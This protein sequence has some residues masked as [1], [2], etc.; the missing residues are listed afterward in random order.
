MFRSEI[1]VKKNIGSIQVLHCELPSIMRWE[2]VNSSKRTR[3][4]R[5]AELNGEKQE[6]KI[7]GVPEIILS[8][9]AELFPKNHKESDSY[10][11]I[12][13]IMGIVDHNKLNCII[14]IRHIRQKM[15]DSVLVRFLS[16]RQNRIRCL[17]VL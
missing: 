14:S 5:I 6:N 3:N 10:D 16:K 13:R 4:A 7:G 2:P 17:N 11:E 8:G 15:I 9:D 12:H 1:R